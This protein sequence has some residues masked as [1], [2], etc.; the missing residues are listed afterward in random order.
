[1][2]G[3]IVRL[4]YVPAGVG[5]RLLGAR[6]GYE[7]SA[8][9]YFFLWMETAEKRR[10]PIR[11]D[12]ARFLKWNW[13]N[14]TPERRNALEKTMPK[15]MDIRVAVGEDGYKADINTENPDLEAWVAKAKIFQEEE[16]RKKRS[17][18]PQRSSR[19]RTAIVAW[20]PHDP[21]LPRRIVLPQSGRRPTCPYG[22]RD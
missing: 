9:S 19:K 6:Y 1:M 20:D 16:A 14:L 12:V 21:R 10:R 7:L 11:I 5:D 15:G 13:G 4:L 3:K 8:P 22:N 18:R 2:F 17:E